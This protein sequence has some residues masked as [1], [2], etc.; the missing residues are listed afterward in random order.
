LDVNT[1]PRDVYAIELVAGQ[2]VV[3]T[4]SGSSTDISVVLANPGAESFSARK[5][6]KAFAM[7]YADAGWSQTFLPEVSGIYYLALGAYQTSQPY[8][9]SVSSTGKTVEGSSIASDVPGTPLAIGGEV[10]SIIDKSTKPRDVY[11]IEL[12]AG[13]EVVFTS[14]APARIFLWC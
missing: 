4:L 5:Y 7:D 10:S 12:V 2:E 14:V 1:K 3:F 13:E 9:V 8:T 11:A 6:T